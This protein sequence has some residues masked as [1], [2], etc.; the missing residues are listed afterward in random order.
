MPHKALKSSLL[1]GTLSMLLFVL[2]ACSS[3]PAPITVTLTD[4]AIHMSSTTAKA[5]KITFRIT[6]GSASDLL[7]EFVIIHT[8]DPFDKLPRDAEG[9]VDEEQL[10]SMGEQGDIEAGK[11][12]DL[13]V[14]LQPGHYLMIC[15]LPGHFAEGMHIEFTV[16]P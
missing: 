4:Y 1:L 2:S 8:D 11:T 14:D 10:M 5:G 15:N 16:T 13:T 3:A 7:H 9:N 6:N 12:V